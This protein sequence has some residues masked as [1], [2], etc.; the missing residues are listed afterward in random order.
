MTGS[1]T[2]YVSNFYVEFVHRKEEFQY[3]FYL[4]LVFQQKQCNVKPIHLKGFIESCYLYNFT[5]STIKLG[6]TPR[7]KFGTFE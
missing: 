1:R 2:S 4:Q 7:M 3:V 6:V 5:Q